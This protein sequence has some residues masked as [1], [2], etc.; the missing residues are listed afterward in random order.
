MVKSRLQLMMSAMMLTRRAVARVPSSDKPTIK[1]GLRF[2]KA[3]S[4]Q[5]FLKL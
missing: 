5:N 4:F 2:F 1:T 3:I